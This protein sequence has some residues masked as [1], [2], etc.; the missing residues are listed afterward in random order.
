MQDFCIRSTTAVIPSAP[1]AR[2]RSVPRTLLRHPAVGRA[3]YGELFA[4]RE[5]EGVITPE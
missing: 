2:L 1:V 5:E 3:R 4:Y